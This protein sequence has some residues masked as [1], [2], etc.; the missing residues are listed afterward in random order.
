[1]RRSTAI[2]LAATTATAVAGNTI[3][4]RDDMAWFLALRRPRGQLPMPAFIAVGAAYYV[5]LGYV[6]ARAVERGDR[7]AVGRTAVVLAYNELWNL[8]LFRRRS[9]AGALVGV[10]AFVLPVETL[11]RALADDVAARR[12]VVAYEAYV[13]AYDIP[14]AYALWRLN[15]RPAAAP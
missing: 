2:S 14:W 15:P 7:A 12:L 9:T 5:A 6:L 11:R 10:T 8:V 1:M 3:V 13:L 4:G